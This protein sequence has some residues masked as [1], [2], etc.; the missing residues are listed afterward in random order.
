[1]DTA[2][3]ILKNGESKLIEDFDTIAINDGV[4]TIVRCE[5][6]SFSIKMEEVESAVVF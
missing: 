6:Y 2:K 4:M 3:V 5:G 1:M